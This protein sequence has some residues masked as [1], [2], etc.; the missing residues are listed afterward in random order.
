MV[1]PYR[2]ME[3]RTDL[4]LFFFAEAFALNVRGV[5]R[6]ALAKDQVFS[7]YLN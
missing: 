2:T 4:D 1:T 3:T 6:I 7:S 5:K